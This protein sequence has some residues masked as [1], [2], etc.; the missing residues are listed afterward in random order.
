MRGLAYRSPVVVILLGVFL[1]SLL[2][3]P[4]LA[5]FVAKFQIFA[6]VYNAFKS[7]STPWLSNIY[8]ALLIIGALNTA[9]SAFY[10]LRVLKTMIFDTPL[11]MI[12]GQA[13]EPLR[14]PTSA[15]SFASLLAVVVLFLGVIVDPAVNASEQSVRGFEKP[16]PPQPILK[17]GN[18][19]G[20]AKEQ[21]NKGRNKGQN[22]SQN[23]G[24]PAIDSK[25]PSKGDGKS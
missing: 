14:I 22:K 4:P 18:A 19:K 3:I 8:M 20:K 24:Q 7:S 2:G 15:V 10:Y 25:N 13:P 17:A 21:N 23:K 6:A 16:K 1:L 11:D 9:F 12:E 5:G